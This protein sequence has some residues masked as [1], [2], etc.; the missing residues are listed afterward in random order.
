[1]AGLPVG[2]WILGIGYWVLGIGYWKKK[3]TVGVFDWQIF[4]TTGFIAET[5]S[6]IKRVVKNFS[7]GY[8][9]QKNGWKKLTSLILTPKKDTITRPTHR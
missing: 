7:T 3:C 5:F 2:P 8:W 6:A 4:L 9:K 1:M